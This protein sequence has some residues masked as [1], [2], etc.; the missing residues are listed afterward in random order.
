MES[1]VQ[2]KLSR[3]Q[4][5]IFAEVEGRSLPIKLCDGVARL[6]TPYL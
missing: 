3:A 4:R 5:L 2:A 1:V 6:F